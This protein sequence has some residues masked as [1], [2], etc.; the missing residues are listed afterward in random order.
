MIKSIVGHPDYTITDSGEVISTKGRE[1]RVLIKDY[2][3]GYPRVS[4]DGQKFY[5]ANLVA[6]HF[7]PNSKEFDCKI[8][9]IDGDKTNCSVENLVWLTS[10][11][12]QLYS[13]YTVE[14]RKYLLKGRT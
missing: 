2:A 10:S 1:P 5:V 12:I 3:N 6:E 11:Q 13:Q 9:Y 4:I 7:L 14:Y 8:F